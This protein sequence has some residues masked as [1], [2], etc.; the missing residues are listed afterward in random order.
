M[1][2]IIVGVVN[3]VLPRYRVDGSSM[4]PNLQDDK[5]L[6]GSPIE[7]WMSDPQR[8]DVVVLQSPDPN[9]PVRVVKRVI[10]LPGELITFE[11]RR[12]YVDGREIAEPY[13]GEVCQPYACMDGQWQLGDDEFFVLG[14][15]RNHSKDSRDYGAVPREHIQ[16]KVWLQYDLPFVVQLHDAINH[17]P[18]LSE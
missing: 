14:D 1:L 16:S 3:F 2:V 5:M 18:F 11:R 9:D 13:L 7:Y 12:L 17:L 6:L 15:N 8:G 10:G 4:E